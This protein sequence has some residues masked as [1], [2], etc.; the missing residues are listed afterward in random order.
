MTAGDMDELISVNDESERL[1]GSDVG[2]FQI[3]R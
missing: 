1:K 3:E 2:E